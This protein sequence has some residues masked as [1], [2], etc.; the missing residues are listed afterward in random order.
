MST[1]QTPG[2]LS[3]GE[4]FDNDG[5]PETVIR[6][7]G[8]LAKYA[9]AVTMDFKNTYGMREANAHRL[10]ACWNALDGVST[11]DI[12]A[13]T[14]CMDEQRRFAA[15]V[16]K[17]GALYAER[18]AELAAAQALVAERD[19]TVEKY[20]QHAKLI[21]AT[22]TDMIA[23]NQAAWIEWR[24]ERGAD[25]AMEWVENGLCGPGLIPGK[26]EPWATEPQAY[27]DANKADP[28]PTCFCGR[29]SNTVWMGQGFCGNAH[30]DEARRKQAAEAAGAT[31]LPLFDGTG[32]GAEV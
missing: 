14:T 5:T 32:P 30:Y 25:A 16:G 23:A 29:P 28:F 7:S 8:E 6:G 4:T 21:G 3:I 26:D 22:M 9:V 17:V 18:D 10:V 12:V 24:R 2:Q 19:A 15:Q 13:F 1:L 27:F 20:R 11:A 31:G